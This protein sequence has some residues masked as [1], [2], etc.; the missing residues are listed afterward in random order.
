M[1]DDLL[2][3][4]VANGGGRKAK[5]AELSNP[6]RASAA[7][8]MRTSVP[9]SRRAGQYVRVTATLLPET[10]EALEEVQRELSAEAQRVLGIETGVKLTDVLRMVIAAGLEAWHEGRLEA[11]LEV[12]TGEPTVAIGSWSRRPIFGVGRGERATSRPIPTTGTNKT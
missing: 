10:V 2:S 1:S 4:L 6:V 9:E 7:A 5:V 11:G 8:R 3:K 12:K